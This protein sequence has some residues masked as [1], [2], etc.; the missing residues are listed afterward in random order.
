MDKNGG[1][2]GSPQL[3]AFESVCRA[4][5]VVVGVPVRAGGW[6]QHKQMAAPAGRRD[7]IAMLGHT[8]TG[9]GSV[10]EDLVAAKRCKLHAGLTA[11]VVVAAAM[12]TMSTREEVAAVVVVVLR[13]V[14]GSTDARGTNNQTSGGY[15][16]P[17]S[18]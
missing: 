17:R 12:M 4:V 8:A 9:A 6:T 2:D 11:V 5:A 7:W 14:A 15:L 16:L 18:R 13:V 3:S 1:W 10:V